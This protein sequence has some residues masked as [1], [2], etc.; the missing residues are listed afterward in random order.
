MYFGDIYGDDGKWDG[1]K[2]ENIL[3]GQFT[4]PHHGEETDGQQRS[5]LQQ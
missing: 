1:L 2:E 5:N 3:D 4:P